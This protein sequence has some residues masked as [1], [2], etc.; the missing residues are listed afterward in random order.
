MDS[1]KRLKFIK[2]EGREDPQ[3]HMQIF[4]DEV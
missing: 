4:Q 1:K 3:L 2:Y